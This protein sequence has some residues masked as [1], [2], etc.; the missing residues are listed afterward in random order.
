MD[1]TPAQQKKQAIMIYIL[2]ILLSIFGVGFHVMQKIKSLRVKFPAF[3]FKQ[4]WGTFFNEE[5]DSL[6][7]SGLVLCVQQ[8]A[9]FIVEYN[10]VKMAA[11]LDA[12]GIFALAFVLGYCGQR[13][14]YKY[15]GTAE[16]VLEKQVD[17]LN[18]VKL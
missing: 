7:V 14:A 15:L 3:P 2:T 10:D 13:V 18:E 1:G 11:W 16:A 5:W 4:I 9:L 6:I 12:W 17:K 8:I